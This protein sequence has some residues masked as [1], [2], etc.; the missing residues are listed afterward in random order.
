MD[1]RSNPAAARPNLFAIGATNYNNDDFEVETAEPGHLHKDLKDK[2]IIT[3]SDVKHMGEMT[4]EKFEAEFC[5]MVLQ[6]KIFVLH[7]N[8]SG[9]SEGTRNSEICDI[10]GLCDDNC[11]LGS[12]IGEKKNFLGSFGPHILYL[13]ARSTEVRLFHDVSQMMKAGMEMD[14]S[15]PT[16]YHL[17]KWHKKNSDAVETMYSDLS[18]DISCTNRALSI[19]N[20]ES[21]KERRSMLLRDNRDLQLKIMEFR[22]RDVLEGILKVLETSH[23]QVQNKINKLNAEI[24]KYEAE[25]A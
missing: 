15:A 10:A 23:Q 21:K 13:E 3:F 20:L 1:G 25:L 5:K 14:G 17:N 11:K 12:C 9:N 6:L 19:S 24:V 16:V 8:R 7:W 2:L 4:A 22:E 18:K